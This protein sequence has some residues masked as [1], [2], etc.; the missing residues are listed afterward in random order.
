LKRG[1]EYTSLILRISISIKI[2]FQSFRNIKFIFSVYRQISTSIL[3][4]YD[5]SRNRKSPSRTTRT[6]SGLLMPWE[7]HMSFL[8]KA[9]NVSTWFHVSC[10]IFLSIRLPLQ[11][12]SMFYDP[13]QAWFNLKSV[14]IHHDPSRLSHDTSWWVI[15]ITRPDHEIFQ[16][17]FNMLIWKQK[18]SWCYLVTAWE[19]QYFLFQNSP[20]F[21]HVNQSFR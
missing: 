2:S 15:I 11:K 6:K 13:T 1:R 20:I 8:G 4:Q 9:L 3:P 5:R 12:N 19:C 17:D 7:G 14:T 18:W 10:N 21:F 16:Q